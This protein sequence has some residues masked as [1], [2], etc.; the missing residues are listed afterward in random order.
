VQVVHA[1]ART[2]AASGTRSASRPMWTDPL[3]HCKP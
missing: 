3:N 1:V 2:T